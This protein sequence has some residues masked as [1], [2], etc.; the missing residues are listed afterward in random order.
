MTIQTWIGVRDIEPSTVRGRADP[1]PS[2]TCNSPLI[3]PAAFPSFMTGV[4]LAL[5]QGWTS[6][7]AVE[8]L[9]SSEGIG[10]LMVWGRQPFP[11]RRCVCLYLCHRHRRTADGSWLPSCRGCAAEVATTLT[12]SGR[13]EP[14]SMPGWQWSLALRSRCWRRGPSRPNWERL[15]TRLVPAPGPFWPRC[16]PA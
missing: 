15:D 10:F 4:R 6:L 13:K 2:D 7:L 14:C 16:N 8:L 5:A 12:G 11:A 3:L 1:S 9:A